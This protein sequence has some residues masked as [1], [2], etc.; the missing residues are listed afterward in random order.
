LGKKL[1]VLYIFLVF[2]F[3]AS[4]A[5][6]KPHRIFGEI[7]DGSGDPVQVEGSI[8][9]QGDTVREFSTDGEGIY[10][11]KI[12]NQE[13]SSDLII[14][15]EGGQ[16]GSVQFQPLEVSERNFE[17]VEDESP[18]DPAEGEDSGGS[19]SG[20]GGG[21]A[22]PGIAP[23][24]EEP[25]N[26]TIEQGNTN[27]SEQNKSE[28]EKKP[29]NTSNTTSVT[30]KQINNATKGEEITV[31]L[32]QE[33]SESNED[34]ETDKGS[35]SEDTDESSSLESSSE[36][37]GL[38]SVSFEAASSDTDGNITITQS[39]NLTQE[40]EDVVETKPEAEVTGYIQVQASVEAV[41]ATFNFQVSE[42]KLQGMNAS[43]QDVVQQRYN[44]TDWRSL[45][46]EYLNKTNSTHNFQAYSPNGFSVFA[47]AIQEIEQIQ[48]TDQNNLELKTL[49]LG[50][51]AGIILTLTVLGLLNRQKIIKSIKKA[52]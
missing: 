52:T 3:S 14:R 15:V 39:D 48:T 49:I 11:I 35:N 5:P 9:H 23:E 18:S 32:T 40:L 38:T 33:D 4:A 12:P 47:I 37:E 51:L 1:I 28:T 26:E 36:D 8:T 43:P 50:L 16:K 31:Q 34:T 17:Y 29:V 6:E 46:T 22:A 2:A 30:E 41:N 13:Y 44:G 27:L 45:E 7:T 42:S 21:G 10:D 19:G 24:Q 20:G 25:E